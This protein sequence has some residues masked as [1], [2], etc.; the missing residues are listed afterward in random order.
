MFNSILKGFTLK[1]LNL[2]FTKP[3]SITTIIKN[4]NFKLWVSDIRFWILFFFVLRLYNINAPIFDSHHWRQADG[5]SIARNF[6]EIDANI[7]YPRID[8]AGEFTG[9]MGSEFP[10]MNYLVFLLY[11]LFGVHWWAGRLV[12]LTLSSIGSYFLFKLLKSIFNK[13]VA[14][15]TV[16]I[17]ITSIWFAH[18]RKFMPDIFSSSLVIIGT[19][20][21]YKF[22]STSQRNYFF[23]P[24]IF[25]LSLGILSKLPAIIGL[26]FLTPIIFNKSVQLKRKLV[27]SAITVFSLIPAVIWYF[28]WAPY[29][30][31]TY[32]YY[33]FYMGD[34]IQV[35]LQFLVRDWQ[36]MIRRFA[37]DAL[38]YTGFIVYCIGLFY[39]LWKKKTKLVFLF[40]SAAIIQVV[41]MLKGAETFV[42]HSYYIIP[43]VP[44]MALIVGYLISQINKPY[45]RYGLLLIIMAEG[46]FNQQHD[47]H[48]KPKETY[49]LELENLADQYSKKEDLIATNGQA[50]P[51]LLYFSHRKGWSLKNEQFTDKRIDLLHRKNCKLIIWDLH[52]GSPAENFNGFSKV[53]T[54]QDFLVFETNH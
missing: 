8:H 48:I 45:L 26:A 49:K 52:Q 50:D 47:F 21:G 36:N 30:T 6:F 41:F 37:V 15:N 43:F 7:L 42:H 53:K 5:L 3:E 28:Y 38:Q 33:Y 25:F 20:Y 23:I 11:K 34:S 10:I 19:Y 24:Y 27:F 31:Q 9:I 46:I 2:V 51:T 40:I 39:M 18:S 44:F 17:L 54:T 1:R 32:G 14:F 29:L 16:L 22:L 4:I 12:N 35:G 13:D